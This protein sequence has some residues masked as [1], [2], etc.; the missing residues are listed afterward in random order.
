MLG[1]GGGRSCDIPFAV[2]LSSAGAVCSAAALDVCW[3]VTASSLQGFCHR[4]LGFQSDA[5]DTFPACSLL[6]TVPI[7]SFGT[8]KKC[9][10]RDCAV[11]EGL[12]ID[13]HRMKGQK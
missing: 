10:G 5:P 3:D 13:L 8:H 2:A 6:G 4:V 12:R 9:F 7:S 11:L 1:G